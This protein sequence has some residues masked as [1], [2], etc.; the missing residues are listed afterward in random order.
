MVSTDDLVWT[1]TFHH[2]MACVDRTKMF[3]QNIHSHVCTTR[4]HGVL[5][6]T[7]LRILTTVSTSNPVPKIIE[8]WKVDGKVT[9]GKLIYRTAVYI[10]TVFNIT[11]F[12]HPLW[13]LLHITS[14]KKLRK[15]TIFNI[16]THFTIRTTYV[17]FQTSTTVIWQGNV[18]ADREIKQQFF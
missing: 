8:N 4:L 14:K 6:Q 2:L 16:N 10:V 5:T 11:H 13:T 18:T 17:E 12:S 9:M 1:Y 7:T 15:Q 3:L